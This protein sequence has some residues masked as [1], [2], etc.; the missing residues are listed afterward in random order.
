MANQKIIVGVMGGSLCGPKQREAAYEVGRAVAESGAVLLCG[1]GSGV[2]EA[3]A[4]GAFEAK[5]LTVGVLPG[6]DKSLANPYII[7]PIVTNLGDARNVINILSADFVVA[8]GGSGGTL[9]EI[10]L[11]IKNGRSVLGY[12]TCR[13]VFSNNE[14]P[15]SFQA[16]EDVEA[17]CRTVRTRIAGLS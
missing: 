12:D 3:A 5:G 14:T 11:A 9:S 13:P 8:V 2:M 10:A 4:R 7:L 16:F 17:L 6:G 1:G 15:E